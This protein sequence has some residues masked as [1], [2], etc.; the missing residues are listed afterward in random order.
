MS[1]GTSTVLVMST[2][3]LSPPLLNDLARVLIGFGVSAPE[4]EE[5]V[6]SVAMT[7]EPEAVADIL[8][9]RRL[10]HA[11]WIA[12]MDGYLHQVGSDFLLTEEEDAPGALT[13]DDDKRS[14]TAG[15]GVSCW[16]SNS[17]FAWLFGPLDGSGLRVPV[18][19]KVQVTEPLTDGMCD[20]HDVLHLAGLKPAVAAVRDRLA[21]LCA[22]D[23]E[24]AE[25]VARPL[26][27]AVEIVDERYRETAPRPRPGTLQTRRYFAAERAALDDEKRSRAPLGRSVYLGCSELAALLDHGDV[28]PPGIRYDVGTFEVTGGTLRVADPCYLE[29]QA[30]HVDRLFGATLPALAGTWRASSFVADRDELG[31]RVSEL[32]VW[33]DGHSARFGSTPSDEFHVLV[34]AG[35]A[36][37]FDTGDVH[38]TDVSQSQSEWTETLGSLVMAAGPSCA[39]VVDDRGVVA[40][41]GLGDGRYRANAWRDDAGLVIAVSLD[42]YDWDWTA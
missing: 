11:A 17:E 8:Q 33:A 16:S 40:E 20:P 26:F 29:E 23:Q 3:D 36:G 32:R 37:C 10:E 31:S 1:A 34:D 41:C 42:L 24:A 27:E 2:P 5:L 4:A 25:R 28:M 21:S 39:S 18:G 30:P 15:G 19:A 14:I 35:M 22:L 6:R 12:P 7:S 13:R 38:R 9:A